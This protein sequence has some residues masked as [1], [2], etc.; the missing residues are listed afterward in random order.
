MNTKKHKIA[1]AA[2]LFL[3]IGTIEMHLALKYILIAV[4][5]IEII[6]VLTQL[7]LQ[8]KVDQLAK[9]DKYD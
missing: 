5:T 2:F 9:E 7:F 3:I 4:A 8:I 1:I 6:I